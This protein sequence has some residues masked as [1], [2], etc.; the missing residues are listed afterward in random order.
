MFHLRLFPTPKFTGPFLFVLLLFFSPL[1]SQNAPLPFYPEGRYAPGIPSP[2]AVLGF[3]LGS[4]PVRHAEARAYFEALAEASPR[5]RLFESGYLT[6][7]QRALYYV[8]ISDES[9]LNRLE[10]IQAKLARLSD[11]RRTS[12]ADSRSLITDLP[13]VAWMMYSIHGDELSGADASLQVAY[14]LAAGTDERSAKLRRE[15]LVGIDPM[16]NPDGRERFLASM[17]QWGGA[18][19][20]SDAQSIHHTGVWPWGRTNHYLFD[21]NRDWFILSQPESR[22]RV[23]ALHEWHPQLVVDAHEMGSFDTFLFNPA[24]EPINHNYSQITLKWTERIAAEQAR[25]F[26][27]YG[28][29]YYT[30]EWLEDWYPGYGS[31]YPYLI[32]AVGFIYEQA[33]TEGSAVRRPD[34]TLLTFRDA[35]HRQFTGSIANLTTAAENRE[36]L[37]G[38]YYR[39]KQEALAGSSGGVEAYYILPGE[40]PS[41]AAE[42]IGKLH[43]QGVEIEVAEAAFTAKSLR[44]YRERRPADRQLPA[45]TYVI[46]TRQPLRPLIDAILEF[47]PRMTNNF[48]RSERESLEKGEGTR[49]YEVSGWSMPLAYGVETYTAR[50]APAVKT[51]PFTGTE[52]AP[53]LS[54][55]D[56]AFGYLIDY[57]DDSG[58]QALLALFE[59]GAKV[60]V[61]RKAFRIGGQRYAPGTLLLRRN[62]NPADLPEMIRI[63]ADDS[64]CRIAG[65]NTAHSEEGPDLGGNDFALLEAPRIAILAGPDISSYNFGT[66]WHLLDQKLRTRFS[67]LEQHNFGRSD[68]RVYNVLIL[69]ASSDYSQIFGKEGT[70]KLKDWINQGGTLIG[71]DDAAAFLSDSATALSKVKQRRQALK[72]LDRYAAAVTLEQA[73]G[74]TPIDSVAI[75]EGIPAASDAKKGEKSKNGETEET[76]QEKSASQELKVL[77]EL[78]ARQRIFRPRGTVCRIMLNPE[79]WLC[80]GAGSEVPAMIATSYAFLSRPPVETPGRFAKAVDLRLSGLLWPE[81]RERWEDSAYLTR[82]ALGKGQIILFAGEPNFRAYFHGTARLLINALLLGPGLGAQPPGW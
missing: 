35:V 19:P 63:L 31:S 18:V 82:E 45:G 24:R 17:Q 61:A 66:L 80:Y 43:F 73:I 42:L 36:A 75:W 76:D 30:R 12:P 20:N 29:S 78:D 7:E 25:A 8:V 5:V 50:S 54:H 56:P 53:A 49:L 55:P 34:G 51:R 57:Q 33:S 6:H 47:D 46:R 1:F 2:E 26:D 52:E 70:Q 67:I 27:R 28:W 64:R 69:P 4:R 79:H 41:R 32:G 14:Q 58:V 21:L 9:N 22:S 48:L 39:M 38:D 59:K 23:Q 74:Q 10:A 11:P 77:Q 13:A 15:L 40:N 81:A 65:I 71:I 37:L 3:P 44:S 62:E 68:L 72:E 60:R 16:E